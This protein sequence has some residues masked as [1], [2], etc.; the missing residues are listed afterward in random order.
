MITQLKLRTDRPIGAIASIL[1]A[2]Y[3]PLFSCALCGVSYYSPFADK[4]PKT[5]VLDG[6]EA[7]TLFGLLFLVSLVVIAAATKVFL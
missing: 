6:K 7:K 5:I 4:A 2:N 1:F 3:I